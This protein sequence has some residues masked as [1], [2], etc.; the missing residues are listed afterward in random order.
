MTDQE[1]FMSSVC[2]LCLVAKCFSCCSRWPES[3]LTTASPWGGSCRHLYWLLSPPRSTMST[4][5]SSVTRTRCSM[6]RTVMQKTRRMWLVCIVIKVVSSA[7]L[8]C[9]RSLS[10][11]YSYFLFYKNEESLPTHL[12]SAF[13]LISRTLDS[14]L[15][16]GTTASPRPRSAHYLH[17]YEGLLVTVSLTLKSGTCLTLVQL[18]HLIPCIHSSS[19]VFSVD[20]K[21]WKIWIQ[22]DQ[23]LV[24][25]F[26]PFALCFVRLLYIY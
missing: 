11:L 12:V 25:V 13:F 16:P 1:E 15:H 10:V 22:F 21:E 5:T 20:L 19:P 7:I 9:S 3:C 4:M 6:T 8:I 23:V 14:L 17:I 24:C 18:C 26:P 2:S